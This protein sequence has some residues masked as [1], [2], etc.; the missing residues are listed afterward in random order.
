VIVPS[1][2]SRISTILD[3][4]IHITSHNSSK[5]KDKTVNRQ[6]TSGIYRLI[7]SYKGGFKVSKYKIMV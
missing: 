4:D 6:T 5:L 3:M 7:S 2:I 1:F